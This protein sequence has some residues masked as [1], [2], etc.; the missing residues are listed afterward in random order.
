MPWIVFQ[1]YLFSLSL[2][3]GGGGALKI[4]PNPKKNI[5]VLITVILKQSDWLIKTS[6]AN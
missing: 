3:I 1:H 6:L 2:S 5:L 4:G